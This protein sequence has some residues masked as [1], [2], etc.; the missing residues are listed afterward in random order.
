MIQNTNWDYFIIAIKGLMR[1]ITQ[2]I[3]MCVFISF[4]LFC[5]YFAVFYNYWHLSYISRISSR[6]IFIFKEIDYFPDYYTF[7]DYS[8]RVDMGRSRQCKVFFL[9]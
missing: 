7:E 3:S 2:Y 8:F 6:R 9:I 5:C 4:V 1:G